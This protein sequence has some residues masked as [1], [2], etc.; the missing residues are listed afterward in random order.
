MVSYYKVEDQL[1]LIA[2]GYEP[3]VAQLAEINHEY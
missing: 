3:N 1:Q 2:F